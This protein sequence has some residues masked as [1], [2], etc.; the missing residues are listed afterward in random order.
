VQ[1][2]SGMTKRLPIYAS[3]GEEIIVYVLVDDDDNAHLAAYS[4]VMQGTPE[5]QVQNVS[6]ATLEKLY[7]NLNCD[8]ADL[9]PS[10][11]A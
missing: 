8:I 6:S 9:F 3:R 2:E 4:W 5:N 10:D 1:K 11:D 7:R